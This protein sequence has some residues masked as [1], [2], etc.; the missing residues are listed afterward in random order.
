MTT[1]IELA[2]DMVFTV[3][4][5]QVRWVDFGRE[6]QSEPDPSFPN[7]RDL[8]VAETGQRCCTVKLP[9]PAKRC[10]VFIAKCQ[11]CGRS[12]GMTTAGR[13]DDP[14]SLRVACRPGKQQ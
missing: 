12:V 5:F 9:Y 6:P 10:G 3:G 11:D 1:D 8:I 2:P 14:R 4:R 13:P 7:G